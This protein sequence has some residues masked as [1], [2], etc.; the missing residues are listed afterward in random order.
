MLFVMVDDIP[1]IAKIIKVS[2]EDIVNSIDLEDNDQYLNIYPNPTNDI[3]FIKSLDQIIELKVIDI[4]GNELLNKKSR[5]IDSVNLYGFADG[6][7][8]F[9]L[10]FENGRY[11]FHKVIKIKK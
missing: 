4:K 9:Y 11:G 6:I 7:Y 3:V 2:D 10:K 8:N 5:N 1:S